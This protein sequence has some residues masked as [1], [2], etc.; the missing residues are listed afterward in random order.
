MPNK[1]VQ[2]GVFDRS[3]AE[4]AGGTPK[5]PVNFQLN[6]LLDHRV[7]SLKAKLQIP[8]AREGH[9]VPNPCIPYGWVARMERTE[10]NTPKIAPKVLRLFERENKI[11]FVEDLNKKDLEIQEAVY[12][13]FPFAMDHPQHQREI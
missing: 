12:F 9:L 2:I 7:V 11:E 6:S 3:S 10:T 4:F 8:S 1:V 13:A 5:Q